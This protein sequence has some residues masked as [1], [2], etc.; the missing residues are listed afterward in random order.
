MWAHLI[1]TSMLNALVSVPLAFWALEWTWDGGRARGMVIGAGAIACQVFAGHLQDTLLTAMALGLYGA[2]RALIEPRAQ[3]RAFVLGTTCGLVMLGVLLS[4]VQWIP[5]KELLDR[6]P[7]GA[8]LSWSDLTHGSWD[9]EL[10]PSLVVRE[11]YGTRA[12]DTDWMDGYYPYHEMNAYLGLV[13]LALAVVGGA[14]SRDRWVGF[15]IILAGLGGVMMLG[16]YTALFDLMPKLPVLGSSRIPVRY[17]LWVSLAVAALSAVGAD[18]LA[19]PGWVKIRGGVALALGMTLVALPILYYIYEP[20]WTET[21]RWTK[22]YHLTR[23]RALRE[24]LLVSSGRTLAVALAGW[25]V[26][27]WAASSSRAGTR[28]R[29]AGVLPLLVIADLLGAHWN[30][31]PSINPDYWTK[32][33]QTA[34]RILA[35]PDHQRVFG[36]GVLHAGEPGYAAGQVNERRFF[37]ARDTLAWSLAPVWGLRSSAGETPIHPRRF[38]AFTDNARLG[39]GRFDV[40]GVTHFLTHQGEEVPGWPRGVLVGSASI[41]RNPTA[42][43]RARLMGQPVYA[44]GEDAAV[45]AVRS[46]GRAV[47]DRLIV[48]DPTRPLDEGTIVSGEARVIHEVPEQVELET[49]CSSASYLFLADAFDPGWTAEVDGRNAPVWPAIVA[50]RAVY[51]PAGDH[52]VVFHYQPAGFMAGLAISVLGLVLGLIAFGWPARRSILDSAHGGLAWPRGWPRWELIAIVLLIAASAI[53]IHG[54]RLE[55]SSRWTGSVHRFTWG[56][57]IEAMRANR[58]L[59]P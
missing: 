51:V 7:R 19:R 5:S 13:A 49:K 59:A 25:A 1:H 16:R 22:S 10:L 41:H 21:W 44:A 8:G 47:K 18:R 39:Q 34:A 45:Q 54:G 11:A 48:E 6:T 4:A 42:L 35:Q 2:Y 29:V 36:L 56:A 3:A 20:A 40:E 52:R 24:E 31:A 23:Y 58:S 43:P 17:H 14:A 50:F 15:W 33:P 38:N 28:R 30:D 9:P 55:L 53:S 26:A 12:K 37:E 57:G 46:L 32:P 27:A